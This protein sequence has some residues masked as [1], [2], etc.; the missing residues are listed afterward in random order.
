MLIL[1]FSFPILPSTKK[2]VSPFAG[3]AIGNRRPAIRMPETRAEL[4]HAGQEV[5]G[6]GHYIDSRLPEERFHIG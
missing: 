3:N 5:G 2:A 1:N 6:L 4:Q